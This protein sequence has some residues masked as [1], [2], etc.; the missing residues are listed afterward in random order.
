MH[1]PGRS[2]MVHFWWWPL[3]KGQLR[4]CWKLQGSVFSNFILSFNSISSDSAVLPSQ[5]YTPLPL[6][7]LLSLGVP[8]I[9]TALITVLSNQSPSSLA[10]DALREKMKDAVVLQVVK[11]CPRGDVSMVVLEEKWACVK[12]TKET[13]RRKHQEC[14]LKVCNVHS[15]ST[16]SPHLP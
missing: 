13:K 2:D 11:R 9:V 12:T 14:P 1:V 4:D 5:G 7:P 15:R 6:Q 16:R 3:C 8:W 10:E